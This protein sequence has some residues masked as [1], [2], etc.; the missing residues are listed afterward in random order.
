VITNLENIFT[1]YMLLLNNLHLFK[2]LIQI[3]IILIVNWVKDSYNCKTKISLLFSSV[4]K[5]GLVTLK[6]FNVVVACPSYS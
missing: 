4:L 1:V 3:M 2:S 6:G 5:L